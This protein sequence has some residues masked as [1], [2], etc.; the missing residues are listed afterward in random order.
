MRKEKYLVTVEDPE[1]LHEGIVVSINLNRG[2]GFIQNLEKKEP[3]AFFH[4]AECLDGFEGLRAGQRVQYIE[5]EAA[6][7][8]R[9]IGV[10]RVKDSPRSC[11]RATD[12]NIENRIT[13][14]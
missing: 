1:T 7:G 5:A 10:R 3:H 8:R 12:Q 6:G 2:F 14:G 4:Q 13:R 9:A 11:S